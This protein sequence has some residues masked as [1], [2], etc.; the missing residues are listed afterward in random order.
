LDDGG[1]I[2]LWQVVWSTA[3]RFDTVL[4][5]LVPADTAAQPVPAPPVPLDI[6]VI[7]IPHRPPVLPLA[8]L[9]GSF[10]R[11]PYTLARYRNRQLDST[12]RRLVAERHPAV[13][14]VNNLHYA[15]YMDSARGIPFVIR[16]Q[17]LEHRW[18]ERFASSRTNPL[19]AAFARF[20]SRRMLRTETD[21]CA[22]ADLVL[23]IQDEE[24]Q[25]LRALAPSA[26]IETVPVGIEFSRYL[27][28][29]REAP[30]IILLVGSFGWPPNDEG[31]RRFLT[32]GWPRVRARRADARLLMIGKDLSSSLTS[33]A[34]EVGAEPIGYVD[35]MLPEFARATALVV[36]LWVGAGARVK[37]VEA[38]AA[39]L[40]VV[41]TPLAAEGLGLQPG[42]HL[43]QAEG[44]AELGD[45]LLALLEAPAYAEEIARNAYAHAR[46][47][48]SLDAVASRTNDLLEAA[49]KR[50]A[51]RGV[52]G[53]STPAPASESAR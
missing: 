40:P 11:W 36:P 14:V 50:H 21:L 15:T 5:S 37:I 12:L 43:L 34:R 45:A 22:R 29:A 2:A 53:G 46:E 4:V 10:G 52:T 42:R 19:V 26:W 8:V 3:Q 16:Q 23:S 24:T 47:R 25:A 41:S 6:E 27:A 51:L 7:R 38:L 48:F 49:I 1:R 9:R 30:P 18:L 17:N 32:G 31:A 20:Q 35:S 33:A 28:P 13:I 44:P 39:K